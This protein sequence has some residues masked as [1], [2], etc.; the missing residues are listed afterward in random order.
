MVRVIFWES[1][2]GTA[3]GVERQAQAGGGSNAYIW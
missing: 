1:S 3:R 2:A